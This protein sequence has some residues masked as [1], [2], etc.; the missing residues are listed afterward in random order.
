MKITLGRSFDGARVIETL[1]KSG[2][3]GM[4]EFVTY[5]QDFASQTV[6]ALRGTLTIGDNLNSL[7]KTIDLIHNVGLTLQLPD[8]KKVPKHVILTK[9]IPFSAAPTSFNWQLTSAGD[10]EIKATFTGS[11]TAAVTVTMVILF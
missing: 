5:L 11:P 6:N 10:L 4:D 3:K 2:V 8:Q 9:A 7:E 1:A